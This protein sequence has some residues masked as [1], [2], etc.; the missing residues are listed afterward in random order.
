MYKVHGVPGNVLYSLVWLTLY[1]KSA[2]LKIAKG[3]WDLKKWSTASEL[4]YPA[5]TTWIS[6]DGGWLL[7][8][9]AMG[10][11]FPVE[12][13]RYYFLT[14]GSRWRQAGR[15]TFRPLHPGGS[16][17]LVIWLGEWLDPTTGLDAVCEGNTFT[18]PGTELRFLGR[19]VPYLDL[20]QTEAPGT[21]LPA[22][23]KI[24]SVY[25][26]LFCDGCNCDPCYVA[27]GT[28]NGRSFD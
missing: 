17:C 4:C 22:W 19:P 27:M 10:L 24:W 6:C 8:Q 25:L 26:N 3:K 20:I 16:S 1:Y 2:G 13:Y 11:W 23:L 28:K 14:F 21:D 15:V 7:L 18:S 12:T 5:G 9:D